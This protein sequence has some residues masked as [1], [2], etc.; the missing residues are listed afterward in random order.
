MTLRHKRLLVTMDDEV[1]RPNVKDDLTTRDDYLV[2]R[3][4]RLSMSNHD[5]TPMSTDEKIKWNL[6]HHD[7]PLYDSN[8]TIQRAV[9]LGQNYIGENE[10]GAYVCRIGGLPIFTSGTRLDRLCNKNLLVFSEPCDEDHIEINSL[11]LNNVSVDLVKDQLEQLLPVAYR[12]TLSAATSF[13]CKRSDTLIGYL[14]I[15][16]HKSSTDYNKFYVAPTK[17]SALTFLPLNISWPLE[18]QPE[19]LWGTEG[20]FTVWNQPTIKRA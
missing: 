7:H 4:V 18:S 13:R 3:F 11:N 17:Y 20:Q 15:F 12:E 6:D 9:L 5:L 19:N 10:K 16:K 2:N 8:R 1:Q 14:L